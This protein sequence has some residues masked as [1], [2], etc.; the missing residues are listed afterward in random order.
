MIA[1]LSPRAD[2]IVFL[3]QEEVEGMAKNEVRGELFGNGS[4]G[5]LLVGVR[6]ERE[7]GRD[8]GIDVRLYLPNT[9]LRVDLGREYYMDF[10]RKGR[11][12]TMYNSVGNTV[13]LIEDSRCSTFDRMQAQQLEYRR[14]REQLRI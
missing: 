9:H 12:L 11:A 2:L 3:S 14:N 8:Y 6:G 10:V 13:C 5:I 7:H 4:R 1:H